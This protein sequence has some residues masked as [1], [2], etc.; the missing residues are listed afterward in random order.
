MHLILPVSNSEID[1]QK[2]KTGKQGCAL[3]GVQKKWV[4]VWPARFIAPDFDNSSTTK[5]TGGSQYKNTL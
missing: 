5:L 4:V 1:Y 2:K 3:G